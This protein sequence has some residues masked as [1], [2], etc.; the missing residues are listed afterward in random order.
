[1]SDNECTCKTHPRPGSALEVATRGASKRIGARLSTDAAR[2]LVNYCSSNDCTQSEGIRRALV[3]LAAS[4]RSP[5]DQKLEALIEVLGLPPDADRSAIVAAIDE[6]IGGPAT[7]QDA[8]SG[9]AEPAANPVGLS[10]GELAA[11]EKI[12][13]PAKKAAFVALRRQRA[14]ERAAGAKKARK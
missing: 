12:K 1:M 5:E 9:D 11:A 10:A 4:T 8:L 7:G 6:L 2:A 13:D 3:V 14:A